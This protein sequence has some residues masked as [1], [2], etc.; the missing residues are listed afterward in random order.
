MFARG[1]RR[2]AVTEKA[3]VGIVEKAF[4]HDRV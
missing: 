1:F 3:E 4:G 2:G